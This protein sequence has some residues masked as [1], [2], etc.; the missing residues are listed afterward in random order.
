MWGPVEMQ[1]P[2]LSPSPASPVPPVSSVSSVSSIAPFLA[3]TSTNSSMPNALALL[4]AARLPHPV[5]CIHDSFAARA[6]ADVV[7]SICGD[8]IFIA[9][10]QPLPIGMPVSVVMHTENIDLHKNDANTYD[11]G[12]AN[13]T[14]R[15]DGVVIDRDEVTP[16]LGEPMGFAVL[17]LG[18]NAMLRQSF[19]QLQ[20]AVSAYP[21]VA[22][23]P[24]RMQD[25]LPAFDPFDPDAIADDA[26]GDLAGI[27]HDELVWEFDGDTMD[28][29]ER[30]T[31]LSGFS[32]DLE[33]PPSNSPVGASIIALHPH[34]ENDSDFV[35]PSIAGVIEEEFDDLME[36]MAP[37]NATTEKLAAKLDTNFGESVTLAAESDSVAEILANRPHEIPHAPA[38]LTGAV[39][40]L[41]PWLHN[42]KEPW[43]VL[44]PARRHPPTRTPTP[45]RTPRV[46]VQRIAYV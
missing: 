14:L 2:T 45:P 10:E 25:G 27:Q 21:V 41:S 43:V 20:R 37:S 12:Q 3:T 18:I 15:F 1:M 33:V 24:V 36:F 34:L 16:N 38:Q 28:M 11:E 31:L 5:S 19:A 42:D 17:V 26:F 32:S 6:R 9:S 44:E 39:I 35:L 13:T 29:Q 30:S 4:R 46:A 23:S 22:T 40:D 8:E 7:W